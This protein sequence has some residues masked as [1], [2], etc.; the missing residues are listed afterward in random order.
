VND[1]R[2]REALRSVPAEDA[3]SRARDVVLAAYREREPALPRTHRLVAPIRRR[4]RLAPAFVILAAL[5]VI[6][7]VLAAVNS[8]GNAVARWVREV[9]GTDHPHARPALVRV[10]GGGRLLVSSP[11]GVWV[12]AADGS[13]RRLGDYA[14]ASWSPRGLYVVAWRDHELFAVEPGGQVRWSLAR[15]G[16]IDMARW[17]PVD[18][19]RIAYLAG[20]TLRIVNGDGTGDHALGRA[21]VGV[22][23]AWRPDARHVLAYAA[24][25][26]RLRVV[27][28]DGGGEWHAR[29]RGI[30][31]LAWAPN[32]RRLAAVRPRGVVL[33]DRGGHRVGVRRPPR[34]MAVDYASWS[35][36]GQLAVVVRGAA[37]SEVR[38][39]QRTLFTGS[40][41]FIGLAWSPS[42]RRMLVPWPAADQWLF[43]SADGGRV[44][45]VAN[46]ARQ[47]GST[48]PVEWC[49]R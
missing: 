9:L 15:R 44:A 20:R 38:V 47:F 21:S 49:C 14:G 11:D 43:L 22:A 3:R 36:R 45:A 4:R 13:R 31:Q 24:R 39:G 33:F 27:A 10:P 32:G 8:P 5:L 2:L 28:V 17:A 37:R 40:G 30:I 12:I 7:V 6:G 1:Q 42:G 18:G 26:G 16:T 48:R 25:D 23:P 19:Y 34:G 46:I 41:R 29:L 35:P